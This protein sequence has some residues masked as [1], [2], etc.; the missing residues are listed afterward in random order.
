MVQPYRQTATKLIDASNKKEKEDVGRIPR[1]RALP[2]FTVVMSTI[3]I[4]QLS[5][6]TRLGLV[7]D[8]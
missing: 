2:K 5:I 6:K 3:K 7:D 8:C 4:W 1:K